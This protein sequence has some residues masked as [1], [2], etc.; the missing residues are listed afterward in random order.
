[1]FATLSILPETHMRALAIPFCFLVSLPSLAAGGGQAN[2]AAEAYSDLVTKSFQKGF[3]EPM[4]ASSNRSEVERK[5]LFE[6]KLKVSK[7]PRCNAYVDLTLAA[8]QPTTF[9]PEALAARRV[10]VRQTLIRG[11]QA[12]CYVKKSPVE[13]MPAGLRT[14]WEPRHARLSTAPNCA[15]YVRQSLKIALSE[16]ATEAAR[17]YALSELY[18]AATQ[19]GCIEP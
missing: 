15:P 18:V 14:F 10:R 8:G 4:M 2:A 19:R 1:M 5:W 17:T 13:A 6:H 7:D 9:T 16:A 11:G 3:A 12:G